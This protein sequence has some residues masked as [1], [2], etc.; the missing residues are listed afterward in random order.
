MKTDTLNGA[1]LA[2]VGDAYYELIIRKYL[3]EKGVTDQN[4][5]HRRAIKYVSAKGQYEII[6]RLKECLTIREEEIFRRGRN[7]K[8]RSHKNA[9]RNEYLNSSGFE[10]VIGYLYL[11]SDYERLSELVQKAI[12]LIEGNYE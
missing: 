10:A 6:G 5:L 7:Y 12:G 9:N 4:E 3:L 8:Y 1:N 11:E 2:Y